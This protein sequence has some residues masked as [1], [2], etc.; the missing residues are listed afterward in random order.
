MINIET[1]EVLTIDSSDEQI[2]E[3]L[4]VVKLKM[5]EFEKIASELSSQAMER[6]K[7]GQKK[8]GDYW[9]IIETKRNVLEFPSK[10]EEKKVKSMI[11]EI[12]KPYQKEKISKYLK[13][14]KY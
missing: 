11:S 6:V 1:G 12:Q 4:K 5:N 7:D 3:A 2:A 8:F 9:D 10:D 13:F 14:P